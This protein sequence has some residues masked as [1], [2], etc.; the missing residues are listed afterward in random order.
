MKARARDSGGSKKQ[1]RL[2][3]VAHTCNLSTREAEA[4]NVKDSVTISDYHV[5]EKEHFYHSREVL[6]AAEMAQQVRPLTFKA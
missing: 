6:G 2:G 1:K 3:T 4:R 5:E